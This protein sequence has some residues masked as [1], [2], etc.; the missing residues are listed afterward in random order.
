MVFGM[1]PGERPV[2]LRHPRLGD[3]EVAFE[4]QVRLADVP[5]AVRSPGKPR[6]VSQPKHRCQQRKEDCGRVSQARGD[7]SQAG[8]IAHEAHRTEQEP[9]EPGCEDSDGEGAERFIGRKAERAE[10]DDE[11]GA[12]CGGDGPESGRR[13]HDAQRTGY[14]TVCCPWAARAFG[15]SEHASHSVS[16]LVNGRSAVL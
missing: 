10:V 9:V 7:A 8:Q 13:H 1:R 6:S 16:T 2:E 11:P 3:V 14:P 12:E 4:P 5:V 15:M